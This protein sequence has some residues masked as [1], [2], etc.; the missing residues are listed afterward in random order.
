MNKADSI[1][2]MYKYLSLL[3]VIIWVFMPLFECVN[4]HWLLLVADL[5][6]QRFVV[7]DSLITMR[8]GVRGDLIQCVV[9]E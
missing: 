1:L 6:D 3:Y 7:Y 4:E 5:Q 8:L 9:T 2:K